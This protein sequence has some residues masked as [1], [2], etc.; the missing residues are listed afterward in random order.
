M[1]EFVFTSPGVKF[2]ERDLSFVTRNVGITTLGLVGETEK[3]PAFEPVFIEDQGQ[4]RDRFGNQ[5]V[6]KLPNGKLQYELPYVANAY[7][8]ESNQLWVTR[9]LGLSGYD[10][11]TA[12][13]IT[14]SAGVDPDTITGTTVTPGSS[15]FSGNT[16]LGVS[17]YG[18]GDTGVSFTGMTKISDSGF[19]GNSV[20]FTAMTYS[21]DT[22]SGEVYTETTLMEGTSY[23]GYENMVLAV[24]RSRGYVTNQINLPSETIFDIS[25]LQITGNTTN[26]GVGD[27]FGE[28][29]LIG[30]KPTELA[31]GKVVYEII[32]YANTSKEAQSKL[33]PTKKDH[34]DAIRKHLESMNIGNVDSL[35]ELITIKE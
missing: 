33:Y 21:A 5:N 16:F 4:F 18:T 25:D 13:A 27:L 3:G 22:G 2:K 29:T 20:S 30:S 32:G 12:W 31:N 14:L 10:A 35:M 9:V 11:G 19:T 28:F 6:S 7:L 23:T 34:N 17:I 15:L 26:I 8:E 24:I 1:A